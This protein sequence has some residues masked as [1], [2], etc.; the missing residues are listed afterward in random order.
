MTHRLPEIS[1]RLTTDFPSFPG[2]IE[3]R[4]SEI[5]YSTFSKKKNIANTE[6][7]IE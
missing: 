5:A 4:E 3:A 1:V 7:Y 6:S 2:I